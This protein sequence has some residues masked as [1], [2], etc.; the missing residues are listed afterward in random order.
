MVPGLRSL[1]CLGEGGYVSDRMTVDANY[2]WCVDIPRD[3]GYIARERIG[4]VVVYNRHIFYIFDWDDQLM[5][6]SVLSG[7]M[8]YAWRPIREAFMQH[9]YPSRWFMGTNGKE[10]GRCREMYRTGWPLRDKRLGRYG[11]FLGPTRHAPS[12]GINHGP[13]ADLIQYKMMT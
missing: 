8:S 11:W 4:C 6:T 1:G 9:D 5:G 2:L 13:M 3:R 12:I 7:Y 10:V